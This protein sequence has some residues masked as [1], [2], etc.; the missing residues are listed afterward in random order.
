M[1]LDFASLYVHGISFPSFPPSELLFVPKHMTVVNF[2]VN[3]FFAIL[4][5]KPY[6][7]QGNILVNPSFVVIL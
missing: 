4:H 7:I 6:S 5:F 1:F 3:P 2:S